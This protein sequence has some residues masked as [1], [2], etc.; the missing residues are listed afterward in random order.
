MGTDEVRKLITHKSQDHLS[1]KS[2]YIAARARDKIFYWFNLSQK[3]QPDSKLFVQTKY[4][5]QNIIIESL[6][7]DRFTMSLKI[8]LSRL[9]CSVLLIYKIDL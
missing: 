6:E 3:K 8:I 1:N 4:N 2:N 5:S 7:T 9:P